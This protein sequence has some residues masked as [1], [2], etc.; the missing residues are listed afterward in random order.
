[1]VSALCLLLL[2]LTAAALAGCASSKAR[3]AS[4]TT[5]SSS[6]SAR[7]LLQQTF[8]ATH[9]LTSG[10]LSFGFTIT[11]SDS[12]TITD[13]ITFSVSGPFQAGTAS[14][15]PS[16]DLTISGSAQGHHAT[17]AVVLAGA[18]GYITLDGAGYAVPAS[19][20]AKLESD[21]SSVAKLGID[22]TSLISDPRIA[23][24]DTIDGAPTT[25]IHGTLNVSAALQGVEKVFAAVAGSSS[26]P[27]AAPDKIRSAE[28]TQIEGELGTPSVDVW[29][30]TSD[31]ILRRLQIGAKLPVSGR[32]SSELGGL[33]SA[34]LTFSYD[35][36]D[37]NQPQT[38]TA[39]ASVKPFAQLVTK[40]R[41]LTQSLGGELLGS[42]LI[43][44]S[45]SGGVLQSFSG[46][47][48]A[49]SAALPK[50][51]TNCVQK[52]GGDTAKLEKCNALLPT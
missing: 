26:T 30:G 29:T 46:S 13:P 32:M 40:I 43:Q 5:A 9:K 1:L 47:S 10:N 17:L 6:T 38:I 44:N 20:L 18:N 45:N 14:T 16:L 49:S 31:K 51:Y 3:L 39:P 42:G 27:G 34:A 22:P 23:G 24:T 21:L 52:A 35:V 12:S 25:H 50:Q 41:S 8:D 28:A 7:S 37:V 36:S 15:L 4:D 33:K 11:P 19:A 2:P 48:T